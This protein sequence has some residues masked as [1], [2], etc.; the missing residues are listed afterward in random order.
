MDFSAN[1]LAALAGLA[2]SE[3]R[4]EIVREQAEAL[5]ESA[6]ARQADQ[7]ESEV[8]QAVRRT[9]RKMIAEGALDLDEFT[10]DSVRLMEEDM[11]EEEMD[12]E[13]AHCGTME[14]EEM[15]EEDMHP[16]EMEEDYDLEEAMHS[17]DME[18]GMHDDMEEGMHGDMEEGMH[19][20]MEEGMHSAE[21]EEGKLYE[22]DGELHLEIDEMTFKLV[23]ANS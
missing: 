12:M 9:I 5:N 18:E 16:A 2:S 13:E 23:P 19:G 6:Q 3:V 17:A 7:N 22:V 10:G 20:D 11:S 14:E 1:R 15:M 8:R 4:H 21:M